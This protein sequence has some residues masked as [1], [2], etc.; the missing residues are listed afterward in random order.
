MCGWHS[1]DRDH[2]LVC[3]VDAARRDAE[4]DADALASKDAVLVNVRER[5]PELADREPVRAEVYER[6]AR[7]FG[8]R[9]A[10]ETR[11][12]EGVFILSGAIWSEH[13][14]LLAPDGSVLVHRD[15]VTVDLTLEEW[16]DNNGPDG[17]RRLQ[18]LLKTL[19]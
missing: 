3:E 12:L 11:V 1:F 10:V 8:R 18:D 2:S 5:L 19:R 15:E 16:L 9:D 17:I 4:R 14:D 13:I 7:R 6:V